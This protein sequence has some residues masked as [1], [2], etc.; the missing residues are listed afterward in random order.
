MTFCVNESVLEAKALGVT[1]SSDLTWN[2]HVENVS[3]K[4]GKRLY[5]LA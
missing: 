4:A 5:K 3:Q 2:A 1:I